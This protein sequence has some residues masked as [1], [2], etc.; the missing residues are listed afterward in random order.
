MTYGLSAATYLALS[1][2]L[3]WVGKLTYGFFHPHARVDRE[4]TA[5]DNLAFAVPLGAYYLGILIVMGAPLSGRPRGDLLREAVAVGGWG[6]LAVVLLNV[7][8]RVNQRWLFGGLDLAHEI[9]ER[10]NVAAG[11]VVA[12]SHLANA[13]LILGALGDEG[14]LLPAAVFWLYAQGLLTLAS[15]VFL[16]L[17]RYD[18]ATELRLGNEAVA[19]SLAGVI[20]AIGNIL[21]MSV[22]GPFE[23]WSSGFAAVTAYALAG[24][25][26]LFVVRQLTDWLLLPGVT[27]RQEVLEQEVPNI[28]VGYLEALFYLGASFLV[29]WSL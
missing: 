15:A 3:C 19:L 27:I 1:F 8:S 25:V 29:G 18:L 23:G 14:G 24:L 22:S 4:L 11:I 6:L 5:R 28:G 7:A 13:L 2:G 9:L 10:N 17:V 26:L 16:R 12:G 21:R 20:V